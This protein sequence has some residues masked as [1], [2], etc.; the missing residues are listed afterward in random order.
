MT[1]TRLYSPRLLRRYAGVI[2]YQ[3]V[4]ALP[5]KPRVGG[6]EI[7]RQ[8][9]SGNP[10]IPLWFFSRSRSDQISLS[11]S[12]SL[13]FIISVSDQILSILSSIFTSIQNTRFSILLCILC[14]Y[15]SNT[16]SQRHQ[17]NHVPRSTI[18][19]TSI[20]SVR[21]AST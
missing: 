4:P 16:T 17:P 19:P 20:S 1:I 10:R 6:A 14:V 9:A 12:L 7:H 21:P 13:S 15:M 5:A 11:L 3:P 8:Y 18:S 2:Y